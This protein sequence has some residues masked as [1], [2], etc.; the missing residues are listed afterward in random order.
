MRPSRRSKLFAKIAICIV[1]F[2]SLVYYLNLTNVFLNSSDSSPFE[3][4]NTS[5]RSNFST[6]LKNNKTLLQIQNNSLTNCINKCTAALKKQLYNVWCIFTK[7]ASNSPMKRKFRTFFDSLVRFSSGDIAFH[8]ITDEE[9]QSIAEN[10]IDYV[11][12]V[13]RKR[14]Q[15]QYYNVHK[16][17]KEIEDIVSVMSSF[18]S[19]KPGTYYSDALFFIS[20]GLHRIA[21]LN[22]DMAIMVDADTKFRSNIKELFKEFDHFN[23]DALFG[24]GPELSPVYRHVLFLYRSKNP[25]TIFGEPG[26][27]GGY[28]GYNSGVILI[29]LKRLRESLEYDQIVGRDSVEHLVEKYEFKG[30][31]GD[32]DFY[33]LLGMERPEMIHTIDCGWN[34]QLCTWWKDRGYADVFANYSRCNSEVKLWHG[35]CNTPIPV[36]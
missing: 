20:L 35:N 11:L 14:V 15:V 4:Q 22:Q 6:S 2:L 10:I 24:L 1:I 26:Y 29:H 33:T 21:P 18:F 5:H 36:D 23:K 19:S 28:P 34:R 8:L 7:V 13:Y 12:F 16:S 9:S 17:A 25:K 27:L 3:A 32:Q 31:L 30:H